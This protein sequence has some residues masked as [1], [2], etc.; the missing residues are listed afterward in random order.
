MTFDTRAGPLSVRRDQGDRLELDFPSRPA[1]PC[2]TSLPLRRALGSNPLY[3]AQARDTLCVFSS[4]QEVLGLK[5]DFRALAQ[6]ET[7]A[8]IATAPGQDCDFVSRFFAPRAGVDEDAVTGS[9]HC[10]LVP[11]W[12]QRLGKTQLHARQVSARGGELFC[13]LRG[14][15]VGIAG[16]AV[17]YLRGEI[18]I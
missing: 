2:A 12:A 3:V 15:R 17:L 6:L 1:V 14:D 13:E 10:T 18:T 7:F 8:C 5:P 16:H 11:Y 9:A 4:A